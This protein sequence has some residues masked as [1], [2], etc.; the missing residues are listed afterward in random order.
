MELGAGTGT[1]GTFVPNFALRDKNLPET[2]ELRP[3]GK[4]S[5]LPVKKKIRVKQTDSLKHFLF[6]QY[7]AKIDKVDRF[8]LVI[9]TGINFVNAQVP[10]K[11]LVPVKFSP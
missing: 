8:S 1:A 10:A 3:V 4:I 9:L 11:N 5:I 7:T 2:I 6:N